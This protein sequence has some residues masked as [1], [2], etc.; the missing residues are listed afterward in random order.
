MNKTLYGSMAVVALALAA[1]P[2]QAQ[3]DLGASAGFFI[4]TSSEVR[5]AFGGAIF[6]FG[7]GGVG[8]QSTGNLKIGTQLD[9]ITGSRN[10]NRMFLVPL[11]L[12]VE[13]A[14]SLD[15][16]GTTIPYVK[17]F[18]GIAYM[19]YGITQAGIRHEDKLIR[20]TYGAELGIV[21]AQRFRLAARYNVFPNTG[22]FDFSGLTL[23][24][25]VSIWP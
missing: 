9:F 8:R 14:L 13:Q 11:T 4:P 24:A 6:K 20:A 18:A 3:F 23:S 7:L 22:G 5:D 2:A 25:T 15:Q 1:T 12:N 10:G 16:S 21:M 17:A 19:D